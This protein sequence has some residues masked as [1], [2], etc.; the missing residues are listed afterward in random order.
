MPQHQQHPQHQQ[1]PQQPQQPPPGMMQ[2]PGMGAPPLGLTAAPTQQEHM[3][4]AQVNAPFHSTMRA[5]TAER[6]PWSFVSCRC[7]VGNRL[8]AAR[9]LVFFLSLTI[10][11]TIQIVFCRASFVIGSSARR[12]RIFLGNGCSVWSSEMTCLCVTVVS[13]LQA[14]WNLSTATGVFF[15]LSSALALCFWI[16]DRHDA[17][18]IL[19]NVSCS[20]FRS[21]AGIR[22]SLT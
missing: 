7:W 5:S 19:S 10:Q 15:E 17:L 2:M 14:P 8:L 9:P 1:Y 20:L 3:Q 16:R 4:L 13:R 21:R 22:S 18:V 11:C 12:R 6:V